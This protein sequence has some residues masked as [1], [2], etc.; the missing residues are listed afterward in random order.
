[1]VLA[2]S[3]PRMSECLKDRPSP[4]FQASTLLGDRRLCLRG[5]LVS[6]EHRGGS[7]FLWELVGGAAMRPSGR[8]RGVLRETGLGRGNNAQEQG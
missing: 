5:F 3:V 6:W 8:G 2:L 7:L 1:M 4:D